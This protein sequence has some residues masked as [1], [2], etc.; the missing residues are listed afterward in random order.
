MPSKGWNLEGGSL[1]LLASASDQAILSVPQLVATSPL[2]LPLWPRGLLPVW[3]IGVP[4]WNDPTL[5]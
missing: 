3:N 2:C 1:S 4:Y 5:A